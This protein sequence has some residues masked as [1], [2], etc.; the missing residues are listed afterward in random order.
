VPYDTTL[1]TPTKQSR[2]SRARNRLRNDPAVTVETAGWDG[3]K[4]LRVPGLE[5]R[6]TSLGPAEFV[7]SR[8]RKDYT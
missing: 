2:S 3:C 4:R 5:I 8:D 7:R 1:A 6:H